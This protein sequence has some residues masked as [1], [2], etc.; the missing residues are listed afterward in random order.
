MSSAGRG[1]LYLLQR[2]AVEHTLRA[3]QGADG[4]V[5]FIF[6]RRL[7]RKTWETGGPS[8]SL[9]RAKL[10]TYPANLTIRLVRFQYPKLTSEIG[11]L[12]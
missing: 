1:T 4:L 6:S 3:L 12:Y 11:L 2:T 10:C 5:N 8:M 9:E 7:R